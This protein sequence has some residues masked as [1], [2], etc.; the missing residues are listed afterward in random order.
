MG[1]RL[2]VLGLIESQFLTMKRS[3]IERRNP[4]QPKNQ[5]KEPQEDV[6]NSV[7]NGKIQDFKKNP[8]RSNR[9]TANP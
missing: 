3:W 4:K 1:E 9:E 5:S 8:L 6:V 2:V 7:K